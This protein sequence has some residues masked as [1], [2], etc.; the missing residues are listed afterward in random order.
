MEQNLRICKKCRQLKQRIEKGKF[1]ETSKDKRFE[2]E[3]GKLW[4][5][6]T[7]PSCNQERLKN[8]MQQV[9]STKSEA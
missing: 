9:R 7:C 4:N 6:S 3:N 1:N 2:D 8:K 5:G